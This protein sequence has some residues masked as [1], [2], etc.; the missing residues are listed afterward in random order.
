MTSLPSYSSSD[1]K[2]K[3]VRVTAPLA[4]GE[5]VDVAKGLDRTLSPQ[6]LSLEPHSK[7]FHCSPLHPSFLSLRWFLHGR[8]CAQVFGKSPARCLNRWRSRQLVYLGMEIA[9]RRTGSRSNISYAGPA[10]RNLK[11]RLALRNGQEPDKLNICMNR[12]G[13]CGVL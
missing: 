13:V 11:D 3:Y 4:F 8:V 10:N 9:R 5:N 7:S 12:L 6:F 1:T 2:V